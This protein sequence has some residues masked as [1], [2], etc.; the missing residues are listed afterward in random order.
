MSE[1]TEKQPKKQICLIASPDLVEWLERMA[2]E[3]HRSVSGQI[4]YYLSMA[5]AEQENPGV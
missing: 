1:N 4:A 2:K 5:K 3:D